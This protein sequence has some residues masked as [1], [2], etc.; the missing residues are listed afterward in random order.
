[1]AYQ[2]TRVNTR[3][4]DKMDFDAWLAQQD[5]AVLLAD[6]PDAGDN[7]TEI[8]SA[9]ANDLPK[10]S[11]NGFVSETVTVSDDGLTTTQV[12]VWESQEQFENLLRINEP[13][14]LGNANCNTS[15]PVVTGIDTEWTANA[16]LIGDVLH[17]W[18]V[19]ASAAA[20]LG[21]ISSVDSNTQIT[22]EANATTT[23]VDKKIYA[24]LEMDA[25]S[26]IWAEY[27]AYLGS[28]TSVSYANI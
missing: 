26:H 4:A 28:T 6:F 14:L 9:D 19:D 27:H 16:L 12:E 17:Y 3:P 11:V 15:S 7:F 20:K 13:R 25:G 10:I 24:F 22:L 18:N 2:V 21:K 23:L 8:L 1:M 5:P